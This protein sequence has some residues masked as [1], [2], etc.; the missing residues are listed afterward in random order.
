MKAK[1]FFEGGI[2]GEGY[3]VGVRRRIRSMAIVWVFIAVFAGFTSSIYHALNSVWA[4]YGTAIL[5]GI[6]GSLFDWRVDS[7]SGD[8][9]D[10]TDRTIWLILFVPVIIVLTD[11]S[12]HLAIGA[13][14][15]FEV[16]Q[17]SLLAGLLGSVLGFTKIAVLGAKFRKARP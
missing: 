10:W 3:L 5:C 6:A 15:G 14:S 13:R 4:A 1:Q 17:A 2:P 9:V 11:A 7:F 12:I 16:F 8:D